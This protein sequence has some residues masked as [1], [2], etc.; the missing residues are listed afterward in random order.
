MSNTSINPAPLSIDDEATN[1][2]ERLMTAKA[3]HAALKEW[4]AGGKVG[5]RP[6]TSVLDELHADHASGRKRTTKKAST[7]APKV[8][9]QWYRQGRPLGASYNSFATLALDGTRGMGDSGSA[10]QLSA[11]ALEALLI[12]NGIPEPRSTTWVFELS[13]GQWIGGVVEGDEAPAELLVE[14]GRANAKRKVAEVEVTWT[15]VR[16]AQRKF[17]VLRGGVEIGRPVRSMAEAVRQMVAAGGP[18][19]AELID[20]T[21]AA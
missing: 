12:E 10:K 2:T 17:S 21:T 15:I 11:A 6:D 1:R 18:Q 16:A 3:Q 8:K 9:V 5:E 7:R 4:E 20:N 13:N 19:E 14:R